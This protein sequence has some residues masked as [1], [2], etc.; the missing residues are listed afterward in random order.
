MLLISLFVSSFL[1]GSVLTAASEAVL[2]YV[3]NQTQLFWLP[4]LVA[5]LGN[6]LGGLTVYALGRIG[7]YA[8]IERYLKKSPEKIQ[9]YKERFRPYA[10]YVVFFS[11][12]PVIGDIFV[13]VSG[14]VGSRLLP[15]LCLMSLG[16][17]LRY[18]LIGYYQLELEVIARRI[19]DFLT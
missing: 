13:L 12:V 1:A 14:L 10:R 9:I 2:L 3:M 16:K 5:T 19:F 11:F 17:F 7:D 4:I 18:L 6:T 15:V 8:K